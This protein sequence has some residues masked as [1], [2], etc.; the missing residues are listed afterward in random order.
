MRERSGPGTR[1]LLVGLGV[2]ALLAVV[3][4]ASRGGIGGNDV[5]SPAPSGSLLDYAFTI[6]LVGYVL[7]IPFLVYALWFQRRERTRVGRRKRGWLANLAT[8]LVFL[9][10]ALAIAQLHRTRLNGPHLRPPPSIGSSTAQLTTS[11][12][13]NEEPSF[14]WPVVAVTAVLVLAGAGAWYLARRRR[15]SLR[16]PLPVGEELALALDDALDDV[17]AEPDPRRA[18]IKAYARMEAILGARGL[19]RHPAEA[20]YEYLARALG[21]LEASGAS[22]ARL[23]DLFERAKFSRHVID[24]E[25]REDAIEAL[26][27]VRDELRGAVAAAGNGVG[28]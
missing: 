9:L 27:A 4:L 16:E 15:G 3:A 10:I 7:A 2:V 23:T 11:G 14:Q 28:P 8:F 26:S 20:P 17:R 12:P 22:V 6:F 5:R 24:P 13:R 1:V 19:P 25:M 21:Q 18:V